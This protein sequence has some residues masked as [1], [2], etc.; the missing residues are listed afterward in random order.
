MAQFNVRI[1][2]NGPQHLIEAPNGA[3]AACRA[4]LKEFTPQ[5][6][7]RATDTTV[8]SGAETVRYRVTALESVEYE[9]GD[10]DRPIFITDLR[11]RRVTR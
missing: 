4:V 7:P 9:S 1:E 11:A 5:P 2:P 6:M 3:L 10:V 8:P